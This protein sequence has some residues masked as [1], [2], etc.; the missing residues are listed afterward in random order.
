MYNY[1]F[2]L[3]FYCFSVM[4]SVGLIQGISL[5][6]KCLGVLLV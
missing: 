4:S 2:F 1:L 3:N 5:S 6:D